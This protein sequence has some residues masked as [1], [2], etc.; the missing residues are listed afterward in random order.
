ML[1]LGKMKTFS[2]VFVLLQLQIRGLVHEELSGSTTRGKGGEVA[3]KNLDLYLCANRSCEV[4]AEHAT[5]G[6][7]EFY[8]KRWKS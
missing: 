8:Y 7:D 4:G 1:F 3:D 2:G 6:H 5:H